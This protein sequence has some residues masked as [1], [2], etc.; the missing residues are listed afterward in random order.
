MSEMPSCYTSAVRTARKDHKCCE[1]RG[2]IQAGEKYHYYSGIWDG[3][4][5]TFKTCEE[6]NELR[7]KADD[8]LNHEDVTPFGYL[9]EACEDNELLVQYVAIKEKRGA[10]VPEWMY[11]QTKGHQ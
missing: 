5:R 2:V 9:Y 1:C 7:C 6:C 4:A 10:V 8:G 11:S 3:I